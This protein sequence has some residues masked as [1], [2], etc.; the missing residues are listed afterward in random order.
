LANEQFNIRV[1]SSETTTRAAKRRRSRFPVIAGLG[2]AVVIAAGI[3]FFVG[4]RAPAPEQNAEQEASPQAAVSAP[5]SRELEAPEEAEAEKEAEEE[6]GRELAV[7]DD[8]QL[9]WVSP[10]EGPPLSLRYVP[11]GTQ[12]LLHLR[13]ADL[14]AHAE[15][16]KIQAALGPWGVQAIAKIEEFTGARLDEI[17]TLLVCI[18][19]EEGSEFGTTL[20][21]EMLEVWDDRRLAERFPE[22]HATTQGSQSYLVVNDRACFLPRADAGKTLV[23]CPLAGATELMEGGTDAP[24]LARDLER[25]LQLS[26][27]HRDLTLVFPTK[28]LQT[29]GSNLLRSAAKDLHWA[30]Q[31]LLADDAAVVAW[32]AHWGDD[33]FLELQSTIAFGRRPRAFAAT[34]RQRMSE[35]PDTLAQTVLEKPPHRYGQKLT[36]RLPEMLRQVSL[37]TRNGEEKGVS[38]MRCYLP[39]AAGHNLLMAAELTLNLRTLAS[40]GAPD[41]SSKLTTVAEKLQKITSLSFTKETF[42]RALEILSEDLGIAIKL[43]GSD[44]Q[45]EGITKNQSFG[46]DLEDLPAREILLEVL[47][48]ANPD[49]SASG[50]ADPKQ[51]LVYVVRETVGDKPGVI[52]V[53]TRTAVAKRGIKLPAVFE[54]ASR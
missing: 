36:E 37:A 25:L 18:Q 27:Q 45:L 22:G 41:P 15:G 43:R 24:P 7:E 40:R 42:E 16:K 14:L 34:V 46:I 51:K 5:V 19:P 32:S 29:S 47:Q 54:P 8:G 11:L 48:R 38:T 33:F 2:F 13:P 49:R 50:P 10:T 44:L 17:D 21:C 39:L 52:V 26:D 23:S 12:L 20:R 35:A 31:E 9:L 28:F 53:T 4:L 30:L 3:F 1:A 6:I